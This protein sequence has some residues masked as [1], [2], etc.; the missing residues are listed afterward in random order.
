MIITR[1]ADDLVIGF[2]RQADAHR[3]LEMMQKRF[4]EFALSLHPEKTRLIEFGRYAVHNRKQRGLGKPETFNFLG[5]TLI[6]GRT[7]QGAFQLKRKT[8][9]DRSRAKLQ[10]IKQELRRRRHYPIPQQ[11]QWLQQVVRGFFAYHA[12]PTNLAALVAFRRRVIEIWWRTLKRRSQRDKTTWQGARKI[13]DDWLPKPKILHPWPSERFAVKHPRWEPYAGKPHV[14]FCGGRAMKR[15]SLPLHR[16][17]FIALLGGAAAWPLAAWAQQ[18]RRIGIMVALP[19]DDPESKKRLAAFRQ[20]LDR[21][22]W[23]EG[24]N[25]HLDYRFAPA[26]A[27]A[28]QFAN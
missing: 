16:R 20:G 28:Q 14:R 24:R 23:L 17:E 13:A 2:E 11:G 3:F 15:T 21:L 6:C 10:E 4:E 19:E 7:R 12:V 9:R 1:Y 5:F 25:I 22:G 27:R 18:A 8:R 26:G